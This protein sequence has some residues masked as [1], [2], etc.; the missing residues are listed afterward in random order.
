MSNSKL[1]RIK[2]AEILGIPYRVSNKC[3]TR[4]GP[5]LVELKE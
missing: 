2:V 5:E 1:R 3:D 4:V